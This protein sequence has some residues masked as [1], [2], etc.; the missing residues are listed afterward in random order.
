M[1]MPLNRRMKRKVEREKNRMLKKAENPLYLLTALKRTKKE[2]EIAERERLMFRNE[3]NMSHQ[4]NER[5]LKREKQLEEELQLQEEKYVRLQVEAKE[6]Q[7]KVEGKE[8]RTKRSRERVRERLE[9]MYPRL[10]YH[11]HFI[12]AF[13]RLREKEQWIFESKLALMECSASLQELPL[14]PFPIKSTRVGTVYELEVSPVFRL[15]FQQA[16]NN[17]HMY[18]LSTKKNGGSHAQDR[19]IQ[20]LRT[21]ATAI[22]SIHL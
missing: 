4:E 21:D 7:T 22:D 12:Q 9:A 6:L 19:M 20:W 13:Y 5:L 8:V 3:R 16:D 11:P 15:Y 17:F 1:T 18:G 2:L 10:S 14:R